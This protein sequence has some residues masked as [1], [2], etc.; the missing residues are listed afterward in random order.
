[1]KKQAALCLFL[2]TIA[3]LLSPPLLFT[4]HATTSYP[5]TFQTQT[6]YSVSNN[7]A[8]LLNMILKSGFHTVYDNFSY[9]GLLENSG[10]W[11]STYGDMYSN[12]TH[13][14]ANQSAYLCVYSSSQTLKSSNFVVLFK[15]VS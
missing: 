5:I 10:K 14:I 7:T 12:G 3:F 1:M 11:I 15:N 8:P 13:L 2:F 9:H 4:V 6:N